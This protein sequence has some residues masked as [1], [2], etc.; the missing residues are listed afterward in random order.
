MKYCIIN[1]TTA[2]KEDAVLISKELLNKN[3][4]ACC[5]IVPNV[6]S[7]YKWNNELIEDSECLMIMKTKTELF[8]KVKEEIKKLHKYDI[9]EI[10][11][12]PVVNGNEEYLNWVNLQINS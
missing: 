8:P 3:L 6:T 10:I 11:C 9:P 1:S 4:I 2:T 12:T 5:N 7:L